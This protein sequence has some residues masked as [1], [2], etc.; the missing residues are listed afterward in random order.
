M[1]SITHSYRGGAGVPRTPP[2]VLPLVIGLLEKHFVSQ[3][4]PCPPLAV[5]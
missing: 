3:A 2:T 1:V 5:N 4:G